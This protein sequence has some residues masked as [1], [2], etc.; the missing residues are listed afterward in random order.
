MN[1][2]SKLCKILSIIVLLAVLAV[3]LPISIPS[4]FGID[5]YSVISESMEPTINVGSLVYTKDVDPSELDTGDIITFKQPEAE[6]PVTHRVMENHPYERELITKGDANEDVDVRPV[7]YDDIIGE[8]KWCV[9]YYGMIADAASGTIGRIAGL[10]FLGTSI[11]LGVLSEILKKPVTGESEAEQQNK[12]KSK[13]KNTELNA[14]ILGVVATVGCFGIFQMMSISSEK[15]R[16]N[17][18]NNELNQYISTTSNF[19]SEVQSPEEKETERPKTKTPEISFEIP[20][21]D[22]EAMRED[23][24]ENV[25]AWIYIPDTT[26]NYPVF[27]DGE[28][29]FYLHHDG[30]G[31]YSDGG[32]I[33]LDGRNVEDFSDTH[34]ILYGHHMADG[35]M[36]AGLRKYKEEEYIKDHKYGVLITEEGVRVIE[37]FA[38]HVAS[39]DEKSWDIEYDGE[40]G[41]AEWL[42]NEAEQSCFESDLKPLTGDSVITLSTCSYEFDN[43]R[44]ILHGVLFPNIKQPE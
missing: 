6:T 7:S 12:K 20:E 40:E 5:A 3:Y 24:Y 28:N 21:V 36:F 27:Y 37:F 39:V 32:A 42:E 18:A 16:T 25:Y 4:L 29:D 9:P 44:F 22:F 13:K 31:N 1:I 19:S 23:G 38:G 30:R 8:V 10:V 34:T 35:T 15:K 14:L 41:Y 43:A 17:E 26:I 2:A 11:L 33:F